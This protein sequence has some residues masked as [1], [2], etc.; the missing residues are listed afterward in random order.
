MD[1]SAF[2]QL[3]IISRRNPDNVDTPGIAVDSDYSRGD[4]QESN[5]IQESTQQYKPIRESTQP[6]KP[7]ME[8]TQEST[9]VP[10]KWGTELRTAAA[11]C[12]EKIT[13]GYKWPIAFARNQDRQPSI[14]AI[15]K[16]GETKMVIKEPKNEY[17][18]N[19][20]DV[21]VTPEIQ[22]VLNELEIYFEEVDLK[23]HVTSGVRTPE[24]QLK[25]IVDKAKECGLDKK[26]PSIL[27]ATVE[28]VDSW[29]DAWD[30]LLNVEEFIVNPPIRTKSKLGQRAGRTIPQSPHTRKKAFDLSGASLDSIKAI[31]EEYQMDGGPIVDIKYEPENNCIHVQIS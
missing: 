15:E 5:P 19:N 12:W 2:D 3:R 7:I 17:I 4:T 26:Y 6:P 18:I 30:E 23:V 28:D 29:R 16:T 10:R 8:S 21:I 14:K 1:E 24:K 20:L 11:K 13:N 31:V 25:I 22:K 27:N 9:L